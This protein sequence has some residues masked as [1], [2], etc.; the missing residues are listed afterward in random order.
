MISAEIP[1]KEKD[2]LTYA[3]VGNH[4]IHGP[5]GNLNTSS[6]CME[7][8]KCKKHFPKKFVNATTVEDEGY[9]IYRRRDTGSII[10]K[11]SVKIDN[12][13]VVPYN[14]NLMVKYDGHI[15][16]EICNQHRSI[17]NLFKYVN[18]GPD[19]IKVSMEVAKNNE[20][21][22][23]CTNITEDHEIKAYV[24]CKYISAMEA[25]WRIYQFDVYYRELVVERLPFHLENEETVVFDPNQNLVKYL[26]SNVVTQTKLTEWMKCNQQYEEARSLTYSDFPT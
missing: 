24:D 17:K 9:L 26:E 14:I 2:P 22:Y 6:P 10:E 12:R 1:D 15:N 5:C 13:F 23:G 19:R 7:N 18:K 20:G 8:G 11:K 16:I 4:N 3:A 25:S 21:S